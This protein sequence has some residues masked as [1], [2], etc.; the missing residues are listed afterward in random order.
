[1]D[2]GFCWVLEGACTGTS[3]LGKGLSTSMIR[4]YSLVVMHELLISMA[5]CRAQALGHVGFA[6]GATQMQ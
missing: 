6:D 4:G 1:M 2:L 5:C 3:L